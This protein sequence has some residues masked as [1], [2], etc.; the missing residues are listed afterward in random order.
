MVVSRVVIWCWLH[1]V[2]R[3]QQQA[4]NFFPIQSSVLF[5]LFLI[6]VAVVKYVKKNIKKT[7]ATT[8]S[9]SD[10]NEKI[11]KKTRKKQSSEREFSCMCAWVRKKTIWKKKWSTIVFSCDSSWNF[12]TIELHS[13]VFKSAFLRMNYVYFGEFS[14]TP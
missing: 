2:R 14:V 8:T 10:N 4:F 7:Q 1:A 13:K 6:V 12:P 11:E 3:R 5:F 9:T